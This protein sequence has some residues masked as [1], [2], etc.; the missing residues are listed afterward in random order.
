MRIALLTN[1]NREIQKK[2]HLEKP[3][4]GPAPEA[5]LRG[6]TQLSDDFEVHVVSCLQKMPLHSPERLATNIHYHPLLIP[7]IGWLKTGYQGCIRAVRKVLHR[8]QPDIVHGQGTE[9]DC[10]LC[11]VFSGYPNVITIHGH[12]SRIAQLTQ[13]GFPSYYWFAERLERFCIG[14]TNGVVCLNSYTKR[15]VEAR[16][17]R[18]WVV[19]NAVHPSFFS[20][21]RSP[22][23]I[24]RILC[25]ANIHPWKNQVGLIK[26]LQ[27]LQATIP[28]E[29]RLAGLGKD[30]DPYFQE[31]ATL[32]KENKWCR[33]LGPLDRAALQKEMSLA[34]VGVLPSFEDNCPM[35]VLEAA[36]AG[37]P[38]AA[39]RIGGIPDLIEHG[40]TGM[41]FSPISS[42]D[43][44]EV[45]KNLLQDPQAASVLAANAR[46]IALHSFSP[47]AI[48]CRHI[49]IYHSILN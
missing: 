11:A 18:T 10:S 20:L 3:V 8:I 2:Y 36:A 23:V 24:P 1:D 35:V 46:K 38:F 45:I 6:F 44:R 28:F 22:I 34:A 5:L 19:P 32:V 26:A 43:M 29:L 31:F 49:R 14:R 48:A 47:E 30:L 21:Q 41:L 15:K 12:M 7:N 25:L 39:S 40:K 27:P 17:S 16:A 4:F 33:Y 37:L 13:A 42:R 9:R